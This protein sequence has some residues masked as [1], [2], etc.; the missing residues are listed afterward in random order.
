MSASNYKHSKKPYP[1]FIFLFQTQGPRSRGRRS[2]TSISTSERKS[3]EI[4]RKREKA[5][6]RGGKERKRHYTQAH[7]PDLKKT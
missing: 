1:S 3:K 5:T 4:R 6:E 7:T 2:E